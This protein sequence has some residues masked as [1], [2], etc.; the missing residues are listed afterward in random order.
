MIRT[1]SYFAIG[2]GH[3]VCEDYAAHGPSA[4]VLCD[5][6]SSS[7]DTDVGARLL[8][9]STLRCI[10]EVS[11]TVS[12]LRCVAQAETLARGL[13]LKTSSL[14]ATL[15]Y[16]Y[17]TPCGE[18]IHVQM[19]GDGHIY[20][21]YLDEGIEAK[22]HTREFEH[23]APFYATYM[24]DT[25][26]M[27][28]WTAMQSDPETTGILDLYLPISEVASVTLVSDGIDT[29]V[30]DKKP[31]EADITELVKFKNTAGEFQKRRMQFFERRLRNENITH[32]DDLS[33]ATLL[34]DH[35]S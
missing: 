28:S 16:A 17:V 9:L 32:E 23:N 20:V 35:E 29:L 14:D 18:H 2:S 33:V 11:A 22:H 19:V 21:Q 31:V 12:T 5:G 13:G 10:E 30:Q 27:S 24:L 1:D 7:K 34:I 3:R 26:R 8:A 25:V 6:C 4:I 15:L